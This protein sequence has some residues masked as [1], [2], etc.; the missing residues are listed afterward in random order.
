VVEKLFSFSNDFNSLLLNE[1]CPIDSIDDLEYYDIQKFFKRNDDLCQ[2]FKLEWNSKYVLFKLI[3]EEKS[4]LK[5]DSKTETKGNK[6]DVKVKHDCVID[7]ATHYLLFKTLSPEVQEFCKLDKRLITQSIAKY[8]YNIKL[9][10]NN[11]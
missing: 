1:F 11:E 3:N 7:A 4:G 6:S 8:L 5:S 10:K 9:K 2:P